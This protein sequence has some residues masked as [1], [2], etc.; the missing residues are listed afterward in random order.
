MSKQPN[1]SLLIGFLVI[2]KYYNSTKEL[3]MHMYQEVH[4]YQEQQNYYRMELIGMKIHLLL[5]TITVNT[6]IIIMAAITM[7]HRSL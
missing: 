1:E 2:Y 7:V 4:M 5:T 6:I 3:G